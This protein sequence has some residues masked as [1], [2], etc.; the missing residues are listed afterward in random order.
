MSTPIRALQARE[1]EVLVVAEP[2][3]GDAHG[4]EVDVVNV[5]HVVLHVVEPR[6]LAVAVVLREHADADVGVFALG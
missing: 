1:I 5:L 6:T 3:V 2:A 4:E